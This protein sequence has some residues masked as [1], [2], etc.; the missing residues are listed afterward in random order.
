MVRTAR[1]GIRFVMVAVG[2]A[3]TIL[4]GLVVDGADPRVSAILGTS[5]LAFTLM[6]CYWEIWCR[7]RSLGGRRG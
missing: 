3:A 2:S 4:G 7:R 5:L 6:W 1:D